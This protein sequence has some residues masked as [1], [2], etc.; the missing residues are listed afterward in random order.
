MLL[1]CRGSTG[2]AVAEVRAILAGLSL[3]TATSDGA[4]AE[5]AVF[6]DDC[7]RAVRRFQQERGVSVDGLVGPETYRALQEA[8]WRLG[9]RVLSYAVGVPLSGDDVA[10]LQ[11]RLLEMGYDAGRADG[12]FGPSTEQALRAF[13]RE[14]GL[15]A[16]GTCGPRTLHALARLGRKV[17]GGRPQLLR[18]DAALHRSGPALVGKRLVLDPAHGGADSGVLV[19]GVREADLVFDLAA[20]LEGRLLALG[21]RVE[22]TRGPD[23]ADA[24]GGAGSVPG[25]GGGHVPSDAERASFA[26]ATGADLVISLHTDAHSSPLASGVATYHFGGGGGVSSTVGERLAG[27]VHREIV[28]RSDL[29][30]CGVHGKTWSLLRLTRMPAIRVEI[31]YLTS[32][33]DRARLLDPT[34]R[35]TVAEGILAAVQRLYLPVEIDPPTGT[36]RLPSGL[37]GT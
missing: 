35:D 3:L 11:E 31:G 10:A 24:A 30:D 25:S 19:D 7:D 1:I 32:P 5:E 34:F 23:P 27:L 21:V 12:V 8:R 9:D 4:G 6:D 36:L 22:L 20:R 29:L 2:P 14:V 13:Q 18:E 28:A 16:D 33:K 26:N 17:V 15:S 37:P